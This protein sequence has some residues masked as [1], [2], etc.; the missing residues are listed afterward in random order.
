MNE[1]PRVLSKQLQ[2]AQQIAHWQAVV[3]TRVSGSASRL[4]PPRRYE[5]MIFGG[6]S[7]AELAASNPDRLLSTFGATPCGLQIAFL[8]VLRL[9]VARANNKLL[10]SGS[11]YGKIVLPFQNNPDRPPLNRSVDR[12]EGRCSLSLGGPA[13]RLPAGV[14]VAGQ[15]HQGLARGTARG[16]RSQATAARRPSRRRRTRKAARLTSWALPTYWLHVALLI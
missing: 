9:P 11:L 12:T 6:A 1:V 16:P 13:E 8:M 14:V 2:V 4:A 5:G 15:E 10:T 3:D 7:F